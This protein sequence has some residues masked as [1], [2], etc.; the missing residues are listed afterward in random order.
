MIERLTKSRVSLIL[1]SLAYSGFCLINSETSDDGQNH[2]IYIIRFTNIQIELANRLT[3]IARL[4]SSPVI[5]AKCC[6]PLQA[7]YEPTAIEDPPPQP[8]FPTEI[9]GRGKEEEINNW[10]PSHC[11][12]AVIGTTA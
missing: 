1:Q 10:T 8:E 12:R 6:S 2:T 5:V 3:F 4:F 9:R 11:V 7:A